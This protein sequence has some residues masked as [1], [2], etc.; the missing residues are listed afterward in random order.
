MQ[1]KN[2]IRV[3]QELR[4]SG[5]RYAIE[6]A[7]A[8]LAGCVFAA[9]LLA[10]CGGNFENRPRIESQGEERDS[11]ASGPCV[12]QPWAMAFG[13]S[14]DASGVIS[15]A[16]MDFLPAY[17]ARLTQT[18]STVAQGAPGSEGLL[19]ASLISAGGDLLS[20]TLFE[21]PRLVG[22]YGKSE[23]RGSYGELLIQLAP[24]TIRL[25]ITN[26]V[27]GAG[28]LDLDLRGDT[29][30]LCLNHP[31]LNLCGNPDGGA[32]LSP[33]GSADLPEAVDQGGTQ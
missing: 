11:G 25:L 28:L 3:W 33:D 7:E 27:T 9:T 4:R 2:G 31:C 23:H 32:S 8:A 14:I 15:N 24:G 20:R 16:S 1:S 10:S 22:G 19:A 21:D 6:D 30:L 17:H 13:F 18:V 5:L 29:Q 12:E 26:W